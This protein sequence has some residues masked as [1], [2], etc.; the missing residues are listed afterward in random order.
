MRTVL[1]LTPP[2]G[3]RYGS[4]VAEVRQ[5]Y[6]TTVAGTIE[7]CFAVLNDFEAYPQWAG[8]VKR[9]EVLGRLPDG[10]AELVHYQLDAGPIKDE[11]TLRYD[12]SAVPAVLRWELVEGQMLRTLVGSYALA[13][14]QGGHTDVTYHLALDVKIPLLGMIKRK[15]EKVIIDTA[16]KELKKRVEG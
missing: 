5:S 8:A 3:S 15:A 11:Y 4:R 12:W 1:R 10:R 16:L 2:H 7:R 9:A 14:G 13:E 6:S